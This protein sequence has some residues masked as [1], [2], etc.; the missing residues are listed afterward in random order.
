M[1]TPNNWSHKRGYHLNGIGKS[2]VYN[3]AEKH[4]EAIIEVMEH[5]HNET[6]I[7]YYT[8]IFGENNNLVKSHKFFNSKENAKENLRKRMSEY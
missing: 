1:K 7:Q 2:I 6:G 8:V 4:L 3:H 5:P